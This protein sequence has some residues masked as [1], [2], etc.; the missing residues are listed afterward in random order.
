MLYRYEQHYGLP[1]GRKKNQQRKE[2][3]A[4]LVTNEWSCLSD[5]CQD[6]EDVVNRKRSNHVQ[7]KLAG[8]KALSKVEQ[9]VEEQFLTGRLLGECS[10]SHTPHSLSLSLS[11]SLSQRVWPQGLGR[12]AD[13]MAMYLRAKNWS[14]T[15]RSSSQRKENKTLILWP[16]PIVKYL[17]GY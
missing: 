2:V 9:H 14:F 11:L 10:H 15:R 8:R 1:I 17:I 3:S 5:G 7:R 13:V 16:T 4:V 6:E 12:V